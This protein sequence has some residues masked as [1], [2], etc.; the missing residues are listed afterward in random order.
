[1]AAKSKKTPARIG[2]PPKPMGPPQ[3]Y[4]WE[5]AVATKLQQ[6]FDALEVPQIDMQTR[7]FL[8]RMVWRHDKHFGG[9]GAERVILLLRTILESEGN[10]ADALNEQTASAVYSC[11]RPEFTGSQV[12]RNL[13]PDSPEIDPAE[14]PRARRLH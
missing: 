5:T 8:K 13:R 12:D 11:M 4:P 3:R 6:I 7:L 9:D 14:V 2:R 10:G 1:M